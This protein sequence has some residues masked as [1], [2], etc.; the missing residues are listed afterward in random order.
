[1]ARMVSFNP[2]QAVTLEQMSAIVKFVRVVTCV[3]GR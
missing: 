1:M 3:D 2:Y